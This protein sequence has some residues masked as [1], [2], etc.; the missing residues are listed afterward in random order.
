MHHSFRNTKQLFS[1]LI[2]IIILLEQRSSF[3]ESFLK[4]CVTEDWMAI[5]GFLQK[6]FKNLLTTDL[7][8]VYYGI[9]DEFIAQRKHSN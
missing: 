6:H 4:H 8:I 7:V 2:I 1:T 5:R 9:I 3:L